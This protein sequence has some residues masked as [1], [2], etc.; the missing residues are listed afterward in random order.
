MEIPSTI[1]VRDSFLLCFQLA[2]TQADACDSV[3][4]KTLRQGGRGIFK[5]RSSK[6]GSSINNLL[7]LFLAQLCLKSYIVIG[8]LSFVFIMQML[9]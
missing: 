3:R 1:F 8:R 6:R 5:S 9:S 4:E 7:P 2:G